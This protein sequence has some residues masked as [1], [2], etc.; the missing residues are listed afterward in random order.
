MIRCWKRLLLGLALWQL[1]CGLGWA[2]TEPESLDSA[3]LYLLVVDA[4]G[5]WEVERQE[6]FA[7]PDILPGLSTDWK[8]LLATRPFRRIA[9]GDRLA[10]LS[11]PERLLAS[12]WAGQFF[13]ARH[14]LVLRPVGQA[15]MEGRLFDLASGR[16]QA[17]VVSREGQGADADPR[18]L[19][20]EDAL[21]KVGVAK[22][23]V[24]A[25][26]DGLYHLSEA[27]HLS[28]QVH[29]EPVESAQR[30]EAFGFTPCGICY[31]QS[32]RDP[33][34]DD[35]D[36]SLGELV[37]AQIEATYPLVGEGESTRR[38]RSVGQRLLEQNRFLD[39][40]YRFEVLDTDTINAYAAP[41]GPIYVT[42]GLLEALES[43]DELAAVLG[44]ELSHSE[45]KH[46]RQQYDKAQQTGI[47]GMVVTV[48]TGFPWASLG[49]DILGTVMVRGYSRG[50]ELEADRDGMMAA[51]AAGFDPEEYLRVQDKLE[52]VQRQKGEGAGLDWLRTHPRGDERKEQLTDILEKTASLRE[53]LDGLEVWDPGLAVYLKGR[54]LILSQ[55]QSELGDYLTRY[56]TFAQ[57]V[58]RPPLAKRE[59]AVVTN[60]LDTP[61]EV[62]ETIDLL[63]PAS[64]P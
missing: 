13:A 56:Q 28:Q 30:A 2:Q 33:L 50:Y 58:D 16:D 42:M 57:A 24:L 38:V 47:L 3:P 53:K 21:L 17:I 14:V 1:F 55:D 15:R 62:W 4:T 51:Y 31:P 49:T 7:V 22:E 5:R 25:H 43:D 18:L 59:R 9:Y 36:R 32:S 12:T 10:L 8:G 45:R 40:G 41:T 37:A 29:Y 48:A 35:L 39:Q 27:S 11:Y 60:P 20:L 61:A 34:Y 54:A 19:A 23:S 26:P 52:E 44:H 64:D 46:A 6:R 63:L